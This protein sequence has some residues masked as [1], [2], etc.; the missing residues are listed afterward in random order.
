MQTANDLTWTERKARAETVA[1]VAW[2]AP[3]P[4]EVAFAA[5]VGPSG[6]EIAAYVNHGRWIAEC[7]DCANAQLA[8]PDDQRFMCNNCA[9]AMNGG[10]WRRVIWPKNRAQLEA[11]LKLR[12]P[13]NQ[14]WTPGE[15]VADLK[16]EN[17][18]N[19]VGK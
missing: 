14:H 12:P 5:K 15:T 4:P 1:Q 2:T 6:T 17:K 7:P 8:C 18:A 3:V 10:L 16:A 13:E 11:V 9:N 19:G